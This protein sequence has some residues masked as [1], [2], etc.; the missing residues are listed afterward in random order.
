MGLAQHVLLIELGCRSHSDQYRLVIRLDLGLLVGPVRECPRGRQC[1][2]VMP[3]IRRKHEVPNIQRQES[4]PGD[5][6]LPRIGPG[7]GQVFRVATMTDEAGTRMLL[8]SEKIQVGRE[9]VAHL[10]GVERLRS[11]IRGVLTH[12][13]RWDDYRFRWRACRS[14]E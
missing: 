9:G 12:Q 7:A 4:E 10:D 13:A 2:L 5:V 8:E 1:R 3:G 6:A 14:I 11:D